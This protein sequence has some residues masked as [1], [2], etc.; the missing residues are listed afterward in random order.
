MFDLISQAKSSL[1][2]SFSFTYF[3]VV[4]ENIPR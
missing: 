2:G 4:V 1:Q 3:A